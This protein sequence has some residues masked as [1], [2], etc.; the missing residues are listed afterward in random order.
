VLKALAAFGAPVAALTAAD[1]CDPEMVFQIGI[2]PNRIDILMGLVGLEF[3]SAWLRAET[4]TYGGVPIRVLGI[5][6]LMLTKRAA[7]RPQ[8]QLDVERLELAS[9]RRR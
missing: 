4:V 9:K 6:D 5:D 3:S 2:E 7:G 8:D 1:L